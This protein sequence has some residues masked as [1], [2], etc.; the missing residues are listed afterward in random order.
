MATTTVKR[1]IHP[2][3]RNQSNSSTVCAILLGLL[4]MTAHHQ[5]MGQ[6]IHHTP[7][8]QECKLIVD[9]WSH[10]I[11]HEDKYSADDLSRVADVTMGC[12]A[13]LKSTDPITS[14]KADVVSQLA[15]NFAAR[16][17]TR[18]LIRHG[19][20]DQFNTEDVAGAR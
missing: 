8:A 10:E 13:T 19:L 3:K 16:R 12:I 20:M 5:A 1:Y 6:E 4:L 15:F 9:V 11:H 2:R 7:N 14:Q 18:F 17:W